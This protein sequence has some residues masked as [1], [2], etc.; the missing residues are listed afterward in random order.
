MEEV[1]QRIKRAIC[2]LIVG[3]KYATG[4][5]IE[6]GYILSVGHLFPDI[7]SPMRIFA[8]F[9]D[10]TRMEVEL[11][12]R[13]YNKQRGEDFAILNPEYEKENLEFLPISL[14]ENLEGEVVSIG[15]GEVL[16]DFS[17][18]KGEI[19]GGD[20]INNK[21]YLLK[22][23]S[24]ELGQLGF[25]GAPIFSLK[26]QAV[27]AI[28]CEATINE[29]GAERDTVLAFPLNRLA[30]EKKVLH[31]IINKPTIAKSEYIEKYMLPIFGKSI[32]GLSH[33][34]NLDAYMRC[35]IVKLLPKEEKRFTVFVAQNSNNILSAA[36]NHHKTR[37]MKYGV[38]GGMLKAKVPIIYDFVNE[39][40]YQLD[41]GGMGKESNV[42]KKGNRGA[43]EDRIALLVAPIRDE[44]ENIVGVLS[45]DFFSVQNKEK[46]IVEIINK[47]STDVGR[48]LY[49]SE[50]YA[51]T[52]SKVLL[53]E[54]VEDIDF[55]TIAP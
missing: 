47:N 3:D 55:L 9:I 54:C 4:F 23:H 46:N 49:L 35:I 43:Q 17:S 29:V 45:F 50:L 5:F 18:A 26:R 12:S 16:K 8:Q 37:P 7:N 20:F 1:I 42:V 21:D 30:E 11:I 13:V 27:V 2:R 36:R 24:K 52:V 15:C 22:I 25:S 33:T 39:K 19:L 31:Y 32:L 40:C 28:Q 53:C 44:N 38:V 51:Q 6:K 14:E 48:I 34:D 41:L 10:G